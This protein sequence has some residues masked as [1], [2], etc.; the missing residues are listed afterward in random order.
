MA[1]TITKIYKKR[2]KVDAVGRLT[3]SNSQKIYQSKK[4]S[5]K[6]PE[7]KY[8]ILSKNRL[9]FVKNFCI[10]GDLNKTESE[11]MH[12]RGFNRIYGT[13]NFKYEY[14]NKIN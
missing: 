10:H 3:M 8:E 1:E 4:R 11:I 2:K 14:I 6:Y 9:Y 12:N 7:F 13:G 5:E